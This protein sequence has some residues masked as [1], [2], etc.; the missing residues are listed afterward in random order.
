MLDNLLLFFS[1]KIYHLFL[2]LFVPK[3]LSSFIFIIFGNASHISLTH[4]Y[5]HI[6]IKLKYK[7]R[8]HI[9]LTFSTHF[10]LHFLTHV[11]N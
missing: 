1:L 9:P 5:S 7:N 11:S 4:F 2:F 6:I 8:I 3:T 10:I